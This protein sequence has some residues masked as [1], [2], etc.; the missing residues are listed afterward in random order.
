MTQDINALLDASLDDLADLPQFA[1]FPAGAH[2]VRVS[3]GSKKIGDHPAVEVKMVLVE[4]IEMANPS[5][6]QPL[7]PGAE[8]NVAFMLDNDIGQGKLKEFLKPFAEATGIP[9]PLSAI[10]EAA[11][12]MEVTVVTKVR[13]D[14][15]DP[16]KKY[17]D[18]AKVTVG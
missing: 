12:G 16:D 3:M 2:R 5:E 8:S 4:T 11:N 9:G 13:K 14:K 10:I 18:I 7:A 1:V 15:N 17:S 6:D